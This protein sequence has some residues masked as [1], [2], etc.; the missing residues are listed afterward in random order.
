MSKSGSVAKSNGAIQQRP[1]AVSV[2]AMIDPQ[3]RRE[4]IAQAA[5]F[6]AQHRGFASGHEQE[7]W[8][9]AEKEVDNVLSAG[10]KRS[11]PASAF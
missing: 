4:L 2:C 9:A 1:E 6:R 10:G 5:Y 3:A 11:G 8:R 7:D